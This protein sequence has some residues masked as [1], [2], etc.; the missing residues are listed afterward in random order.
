MVTSIMLAQFICERARRIRTLSLLL[1]IYYVTYL[2]EDS[3]SDRYPFVQQNFS[4]G[5]N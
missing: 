4:F 3:E 2:F 5:S 1:F